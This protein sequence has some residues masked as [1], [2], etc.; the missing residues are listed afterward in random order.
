MSAAIDSLNTSWMA[1]E[2]LS[3]ITVAVAA[4]TD[5]RVQRL[6]RLLDRKGML[7]TR[8]FAGFEEP[9][10]EL[11][12]AEQDCYVVD[13]AADD[14]RA[15]RW[16]RRSRNSE[17]HVG[18]VVVCAQSEKRQALR[19]VVAGADALIFTE[20]LELALSSVVGCAAAGQL[21]LPRS[22][23]Q[24]LAPPALSHREK[25]VLELAIRG[26]TNRQIAS[27]L[28]LAESTV[29]THMSSAFRRLGVRSRRE[30]TALFCATDNQARRHLL[31]ASSWAAP[32]L[33]MTTRRNGSEARWGGQG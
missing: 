26:L 8:T 1:A 7:V 33:E 17:P 11:P 16:V 13:A 31:P 25:E 30:A 27:T 23:R 15:E 4:A 2:P 5:G 19:Y 10:A 21:S 32:R 9:V 29:K 12:Q 18:I 28:F 6:A 22:M 24:M 20:D 14:G 3:V